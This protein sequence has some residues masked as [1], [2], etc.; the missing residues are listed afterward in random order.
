MEQDS[1]P[2]KKPMHIW[3]VNLQQRCQEYTMGKGQS[4]LQ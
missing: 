1:E 3:S 2:R 4:P